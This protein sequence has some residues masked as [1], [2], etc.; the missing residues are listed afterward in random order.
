MLQ[1][2]SI[3]KSCIN[4]KLVD[5][6]DGTPVLDVKPYLPHDT[7]PLDESLKLSKADIFTGLS[8]TRTALCVP[9]WIYEAEITMRNVILSDAVER[10]LS[11]MQDC[12]QFHH[13]TG[14]ANAVSLIQEVLQQ[15]IRSH[16]QGRGSDTLQE[17]IYECKLDSFTI[18][19][20][21]FEDY[22]LVEEIQY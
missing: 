4:V 20:R 16:H 3:G 17:Q 10:C 6:V 8:T 13:C 14:K 18:K 7:V 11:S 22:V 15:D 12:K 2:V 21:T 1:V 19:F 5:M 9:S